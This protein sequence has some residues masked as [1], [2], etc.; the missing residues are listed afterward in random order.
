MKD[1]LQFIKRLFVL[2]VVFIYS[3]QQLVSQVPSDLMNNCKQWKITYPT[4]EEDKTLCGEP[5]N[6]YFLVNDTKDA[7]VF[8]VPIRSNNGSTPNSDYIRSEL[9]ER[10]QDGSVDIYWTTEGSHMVYVKQAITHLPIK[11]PHLVATQIHGDKEAGIDDSMVM[12]LEDRHLFLSFNGG[13]LRSDLTINSNY[14]LGTIHEVIFLVVNGKHYCYYSEDGNLLAAYNNN[15]ASSYLIK[16]GANDFV[17]DLNYDKSY[18]KIGNYTQSNPD[19]EGDETDKVDNYGEVLVYDFSVVHD[20]VSVTGVT[21]SP[22]SVDLLLNSTKEL[23]ASVSPVSASNIGVTYSSSNPSV[24]TVHNLS[25]LVTAVSIGKATITVTTEEGGFTDVCEITVVAPSEGNNLALNKPVSS[26]GIHDGTYVVENLVDGSTATKWSVSGFPQTALIDLGA[27]Y[28]LKRSELV[29]HNDRDYQ[30]TVS[31][32]KTE[33]GNYTQVVD[34][35]NNSTSGSISNPIINDFNYDKGRYVKLTVTGA[36][37]YDGSWMSLSEFRIFG[38]SS[39]G[40]TDMLDDDADGVL[41]SVDKCANTPVGAK[42]DANGCVL[43]AQ[44]NFIIKSVGE[45]CIDKNNGQI[46]ITAKENQNYLLTVNNE[47]YSFTT[48]K[49]IND[50]VPGLYNICIEVEGVT[51]SNCYVSEVAAGAT[52]LSKSNLKK[53]ELNIEVLEGT[54][55]FEVYLNE[56]LQFVTSL[57]SFHLNVQFNDS[58]EV[59]TAKECEGVY[60]KRIQQNIQNLSVYP[61]PSSGV[62]TVEVPSNQKLVFVKVFNQMSQILLSNFIEIK[63]SKFQI[64]LTDSPVGVYF[65]KVNLE[66]EIL[67]KIVKID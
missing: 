50:L 4:G 23:S 1:Y 20:E 13:K 38:T 9:R 48:S 12:R 58:V 26:T 10:V 7:I 16:D 18:F 63:D 15:N 21:V 11:K 41:N 17:M 57:T 62:F 51:S 59:K 35:S 64:D 65:V 39:S 40:N 27:E 37:T 32:S 14:S 33:D 3:S 42:V 24:A 2:F 54:E 5:N 30:F 45:T 36:A 28:T 43:L 56:E 52:I 53:N 49:I 8:R 22:S 34:R 66:K 46:I 19:K 67:M 55:P 47:S 44:D 31:I 29:C 61:N 25:G 60:K 6:E